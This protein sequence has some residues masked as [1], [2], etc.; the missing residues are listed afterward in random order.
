MAIPRPPCHDHPGLCLRYFLL[1]L[2]LVSVVSFCFHGLLP[3]YSSRWGLNDG[4][5]YRMEKSDSSGSFSASLNSKSHDGAVTAINPQPV[6]HAAGE[7]TKET[8]QCVA[9]A[10]TRTSVSPVPER[11]P[12]SVDKKARP[13]PPLPPSANPSRP[14]PPPPPQKPPNVAGS[15]RSQRK[16]TECFRIISSVY[17]RSYPMRPIDVCVLQVI[18]SEI[19][20]KSPVTNNKKPVCRTCCRR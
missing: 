13:P 6:G 16:M 1:F 9:I 5:S 11:K 19:A 2:L 4:L 10:C 12:E 17:E 3:V 18:A 14:P 20:N 7:M 15:P 8:S